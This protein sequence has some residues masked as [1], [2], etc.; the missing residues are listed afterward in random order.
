MFTVF[1]IFAATFCRGVEFHPFV[2]YKKEH[3]FN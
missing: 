1:T 3:E 2:A